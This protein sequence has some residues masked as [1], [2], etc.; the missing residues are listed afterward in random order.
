MNI[1]ITGSKG[2]IGTNV[3]L[4]LSSLNGINIFEYNRDI[5]RHLLDVFIKKSDI[6]LHFAAVNR[7]KFKEEFYE[8][9]LKLTKEIIQLLKNSKHPLKL[10]FA[11]STQ[12]YDKTEYGKIKLAEEKLILKINS[13]KNVTTKILR[14]PN[15]FGK[16]SKPNYNS[17]VA[18][19][20]YNVARDI[21]IKI[22]D[23]EKNL[24][25]IYIDDLV[26]KIN[27]LIFN[28]KS[29]QIFVESFKTAN[30]TL[31]KISSLIKS[32]KK[33]RE[34]L[35]I[36]KV[37]TGFERALYATYLSYL[38][39][40]DFSYNLTEYSDIRGKFVEIL[41]T[42]NSGQFSYFTAKP[43]ITRGNHYHHTKNEKFLIVRGVGKFLFKNM[44]DGEKKELI[45]SEKKSE[46]V[47]TIPGW[48]H[49]ITNIGSE[50]LIVLIWANEVFDKNLPDTYMEEL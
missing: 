12:V 16:W 44:I 48:A 22:T 23:P 49:N 37:G 24:N 28:D 32:F 26:A 18:T 15:V 5:D 50:E 39:K 36:L 4:Y 8:N 7:P 29:D 6:I 10:I 38:P 20:C 31:G 19:F 46:I 42:K 33:S 40:K 30:I 3:K 1:L 43:G 11:S 2:F 45:V 9:N 25:L 17:V 41:K 13:K 34:D 27:S 35:K 47:E 14:I 21:K